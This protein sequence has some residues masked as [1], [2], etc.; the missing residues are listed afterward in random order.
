MTHDSI[1]LRPEDD[2]LNQKKTEL[3]RLE[4]QLADRELYLTA[5]RSELRAFEHTYVNIVGK[6]YAELDEIEAKIAECVARAR[7]EDGKAQSAANQARS[8]AE[9]SSA[10]VTKDL[11]ERP[12]RS[13]PKQSQTIKSLYRD[14]AKRI[15]PDLATDDMD[16]LHRER[17]MAEANRAYEEGDEARLRAILEEYEFSPESVKGEGPAAELVRI[18]RKIAQVSRR[19]VEIDKE[20][21]KLEQ[22]DHFKLKTEVVHAAEEGRD[23]L[24]EMAEDLDAK[25]AALRV[26][27]E[28]FTQR[29]G[30]VWNAKAEKTT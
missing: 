27:L 5:L 4:T 9:A 16:R 13:S 1:R 6:R 25:I 28:D 30:R 20:V 11:A 24:R 17:L 26:R 23:L 29:Q 8:Q 18:I 12:E 3:L 21:L 14:V 2:E 22:S 10:A 15:H 7:P 19:L